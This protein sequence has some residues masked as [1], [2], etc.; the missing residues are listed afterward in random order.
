[1]NRPNHFQWIHYTEIEISFKLRHESYPT[2]LHSW[3]ESRFDRIVLIVLMWW[4]D[5]LWR[6]LTNELA[7][8]WISKSKN[9]TENVELTTIYG[10][11]MWLSNVS[12]PRELIEWI[13]I[14][15][16]KTD[17]IKFGL[18]YLRVVSDW[19]ARWQ[20][21]ASFANCRNIGQTFGEI[22]FK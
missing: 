14:R 3:Q 22:F 18:R 13:F 21:I 10:I 11:K 16:E 1:M 7:A 9:S 4:T 12:L 5:A 6:R 17:P 15:I 8:F 2:S 20:A 19:S